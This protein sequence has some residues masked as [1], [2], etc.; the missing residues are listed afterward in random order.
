MWIWDWIALLSYFILFLFFFTS[1]IHTSIAVDFPV[2]LKQQIIIWF[3]CFTVLRQE[4]VL[5]AAWFDGS[6][7]VPA[8]CIAELMITVYNPSQTPIP[9]HFFYLPWRVK[10][11]F[12][13]S[14][15]P[16]ENCRDE[17]IGHGE[18]TAHIAHD[19]TKVM[20]QDDNF[21]QGGKSFFI[22]NQCESVLKKLSRI[23]AMFVQQV[24]PLWMPS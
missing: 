2:G 20:E 1:D 10:L 5:Q 8:S 15:W 11:T 24:S 12:F 3:K 21:L 19:R 7:C 4:T 9:A 16:K 17:R 13:S 22:F 6:P 14:L 23:C 18:V